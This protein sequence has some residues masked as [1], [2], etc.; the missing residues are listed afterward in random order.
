M[1]F[2]VPVAAVALALS[3]LL[4]VHPLR[5]H[6]RSM[7][8]ALKEGDLRLALRGWAAGAPRRN[9]LWVVDSPQG[10]AVKRVAALP[11]ERVELKD[12]DLL[13]DGR[14]ASP[15]EGARLE[16]QD[17]VWFCADGYF[18]LGDNRPASQDSRAW[19]PLPRSAFRTR[20]ME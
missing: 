9:E 3:P 14:R 16:R 8:P 2:W 18:L 6:G 19:G 11:G 7:E 5:I 4:V 1:K 13:V 10:P 17:G 15:P 20:I 12:G